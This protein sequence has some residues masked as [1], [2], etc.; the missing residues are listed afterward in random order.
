MDFDFLDSPLVA[1]V[2]VPQPLNLRPG[3][4]PDILIPQSLDCRPYNKVQPAHIEVRIRRLT[5]PGL[6][7]G[8]AA[9]TSEKGFSPKEEDTEKFV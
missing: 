5:Y 4:I 3:S 7:P 6:Q 2:Q 9:A 8:V 1:E